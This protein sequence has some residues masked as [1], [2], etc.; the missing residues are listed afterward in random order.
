MENFNLTKN[1]LY[2]SQILL[3]F[4]HRLYIDIDYK[5]KTIKDIK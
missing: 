2:I 5:H 1:S 4:A 3:I